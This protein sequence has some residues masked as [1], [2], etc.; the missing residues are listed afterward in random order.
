[1]IYST[2]SVLEQENEQI[3]RRAL[4]RANAEV[5]PLALEGFDAVPKLPVSIEGTLCVCPDA[6]YEG[7]Y[8]A[9][10]RRKK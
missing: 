3:V 10:L 9:K 6:L 1:M 2:C 7:F 8:V 5:V 4:K